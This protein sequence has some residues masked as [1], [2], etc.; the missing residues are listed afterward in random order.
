MVFPV[1]LLA[2]KQRR[3][4][5]RA[6]RAEERSV[7]RKYLRKA[8]LA[9][10]NLLFFLGGLGAAA[11]SPFPDAA[12]PLVMAAEMTYLAGL[13]AIP[14][15]RQA[16]DAEEHARERGA[17]AAGGPPGTDQRLAQLAVAGMMRKLPAESLRRFE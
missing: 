11:L 13:T 1:W 3:E 6:R 12:L 5:R 4:E 7:V 15:F 8:F 16:V 10:Y 9:P 2:A 17:A 14:R